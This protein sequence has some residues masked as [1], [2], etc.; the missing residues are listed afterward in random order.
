MEQKAMQFSK[1]FS[2]R[3]ESA[4]F[5]ILKKDL[6]P[7]GQTVQ[8]AEAW[9][10]TYLGRPETGLTDKDKDDPAIRKAIDFVASCIVINDPANSH[11][12]I[13]YLNLNDVI[14]IRLRDGQDSNKS[15]KSIMRAV[16]LMLA[17]KIDQADWVNV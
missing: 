11:A 14:S 1:E 6:E 3:L 10:S 12:D 17:G 5:E 2:E 16:D 9:V 15:F 7:D 13:N 8:V 4:V